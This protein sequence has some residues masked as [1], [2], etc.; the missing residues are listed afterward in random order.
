MVFGVIDHKRLK[1]LTAG[2]WMPVQVHVFN[3]PKLRRST[4]VGRCRVFIVFKAPV[5]PVLHF[6]LISDNLFARYVIIV[7]SQAFIFQ[8]IF[9]NKDSIDLLYRCF[10]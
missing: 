10:I 7:S 6:P 2:I 8:F 4:Y 1:W 3:D 5:D 9:A